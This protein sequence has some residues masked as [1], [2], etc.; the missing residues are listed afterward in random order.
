MCVIYWL[1]S[2]SMLNK[3]TKKDSLSLMATLVGDAVRKNA[4]KH[5]NRWSWYT[6]FMAAASE[7]ISQ[8]IPVVDFVL[9]LRDAR[10]I[11]FLCIVEL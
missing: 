8:R 3:M 1:P 10:V 11:S 7:A 6:P 2:I 4:G 5:K 9:D